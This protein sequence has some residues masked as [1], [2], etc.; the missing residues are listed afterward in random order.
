MSRSATSSPTGR[1]PSSEQDSVM[2]YSL[3]R[4]ATRFELSL[5]VEITQTCLRLIGSQVF[6]LDSIME[7][8]LKQ[9]ADHLANQQALAG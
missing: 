1:I 6:D 3:N 2:E 9:V 5:H 4:S 7:F 8:S